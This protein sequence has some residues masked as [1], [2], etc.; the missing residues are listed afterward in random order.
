VW[1]GAKSY[2]GEKAW[3][4]INFYI[5]WFPD[6]KKMKIEIISRESEGE[7]E[8]RHFEQFGIV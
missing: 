2:D 5:F 6:L 4:S 7:I 3:F 8:V 1:G